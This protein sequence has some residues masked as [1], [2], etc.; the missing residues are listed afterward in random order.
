MGLQ[1]NPTADYAL[2]S[3]EQATA[4]YAD[5]LN[6]ERGAIIDAIT[7]SPDDSPATVARKI[8]FRAIGGELLTMGNN[9]WAYWKNVLRS[10]L[11]MHLFF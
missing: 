7:P 6:T 1:D 2:D 5:S 10:S 4:D 11:R 3:I 9:M 8:M